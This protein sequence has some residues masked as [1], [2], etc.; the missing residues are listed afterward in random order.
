MMNTGMLIGKNSM[1]F[2]IKG[3][4]INQ[5]F[6]SDITGGRFIRKDSIFRHFIGSAKFPAEKNRYHLYV[7]HAC[8][9]A[10]RATLYRELK[11]LTSVIPMTAV[12][13]VML[14]NGWEIDPSTDSCN[15]KNYLHQIYSLANTNYEG[16]VTVPM[17]W[18][19]HTRTIVNNESS[20][21]I[22]MFNQEFNMITGNKLDFYPKS[23]RSDID[24]MNE[25]IYSAI[26]N[27]VYKVGFATSQAVYTEEVNRLFNALEKIEKHLSRQ[28]YLVGNQLTEADI[29][30]F[31][32]LIRFDPVYVG[33]FKC[34][35]Q[36]IVDYPNLSGYLRDIY[37]TKNIK[38][39]VDMDH[40]KT[41]Y[42]TSHPFINP[43]GIVP[44]GPR[45][46]YDEP[47]NRAKME[48]I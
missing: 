14:E 22:R 13:P 41:H 15:E 37:Q 44:I 17:L 9:W 6:G 33:H 2:M 19:K 3:K 18:D 5:N 29:C 32:T 1:G 31:T 25:F 24:K 23:K 30:L 36:R 26:N 43:N 4:W 20:E 42:Y 21:I 28:R 46:N 35:L 45:I 16:R 47:H 8:P 10:H 40:I 12:K 34:N 48:Y 27:G 39:T 7:S 38:S 11:S